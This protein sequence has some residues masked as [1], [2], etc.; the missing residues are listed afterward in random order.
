MIPTT[1]FLAFVIYLLVVIADGSSQL[2]VNQKKIES[3]GMAKD[4]S[5]WDNRLLHE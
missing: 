3:N 4:G 2:Y 1:R 5:L